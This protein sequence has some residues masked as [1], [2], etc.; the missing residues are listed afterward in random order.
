[1]K[2]GNNAVET[3]I[4]DGR[5]KDLTLDVNSFALVQQTTTLSTED[6][7]KHPEK[8]TDVYYTE[9]AEM[10]KKRLEPLMLRCSTI[11]CVAQTTMPMVTG[12]THQCNPM[13]MASTVIQVPTVQSSCS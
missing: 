10:F 7:Y 4:Y 5:G 2:G 13:L 1:M 3:T 11:R 6:F 12:L 8:I 9:M